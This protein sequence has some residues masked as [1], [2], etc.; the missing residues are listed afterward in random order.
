[1]AV[2]LKT[3]FPGEIVV[4]HPDTGE[5]L[6]IAVG[7]KRLTV[8]E[9]REFRS[10]YDQVSNPPSERYIFRKADEQERAV[11]GTNDKTG[12][13]I[14][15]DYT[16]GDEDIRTRRI[17]EMDDATR[18]DFYRL[19][20]EEEIAAEAFMRDVFARFIR[21]DSG[22]LEADDGTDIASDGTRFLD[23][24]AGQQ[25]LIKYLVRLV[26]VE[27]TLS[28]ARKNVW[29]SLF[30]LQRSWNAHVPAA[31]GTTPAPTVV[32]VGP[33]DCARTEGARAH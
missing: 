9:Y 15:G 26:W 18:K 19:D 21:F 14:L 7:I 12:D 29:K 30:A 10:G 31:A 3:H 11:V 32:A 6:T 2:R 1:M 24:F 17:R 22:Q 20:S 13:P 8:G 25:D 33:E 4:D 5:P 28:A 27:N 16:I 23:L